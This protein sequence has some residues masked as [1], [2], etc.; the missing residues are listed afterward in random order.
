MVPS[1]NKAVDVHNLPEGGITVQTI[2]NAGENLL[3]FI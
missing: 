2:G 1:V 3:Y